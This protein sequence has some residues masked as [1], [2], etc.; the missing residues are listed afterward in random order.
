MQG[1]DCGY[2]KDSF[3]SNSVE[4]EGIKTRVVE[5]LPVPKIRH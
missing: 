1:G 4:F 2:I 3:V 5:P